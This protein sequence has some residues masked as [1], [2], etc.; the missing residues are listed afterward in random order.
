[1][2]KEPESPKFS[3]LGNLWQRPATFARGIRL[4]LRTAAL[5]DVPGIGAIYPDD[6][7]S[8]FWAPGDGTKVDL[9]AAGGPPTGA[10]GGD[11]SK[12][13][14]SPDVVGFQ[15]TSGPTGLTFAGIPDGTFLKRSGTTVIGTVASTSE[16]LTYPG[17]ILS[18][19]TIYASLRVSAG[20]KVTGVKVSTITAP[21]FTSAGGSFTLAVAKGID[22]SGNNML[23]GA[24]F[25][26]ELI[27]PQVDTNVGLTLVSA[28]L[29]FAAAGYMRVSV[30]SSVDDLTPAAE[31]DALLVTILTEP[32]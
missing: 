14:P 30:V 6:T 3:L 26:F 16:F 13:Y 18:G 24:T 4:A 10:A 27:L 2:A 17:N 15:E 22:G 1:M 9:A 12:L 7:G 23:S 8:L 32:I 31:T 29:E 25:D 28:D 11:L 5:R 19:N 21:V 20:R